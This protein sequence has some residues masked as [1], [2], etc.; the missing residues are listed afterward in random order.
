MSLVSLSGIGVDFGATTLLRDVTFTVDRGERWGIVGR[1]GTGKTTLF[2]IMTGEQQPTRGQIARMQG[3]RWSVLEQHRDYGDATTVWEAA[4][5]ACAE[6]LKLE[7]SLSEQANALAEAG[8]QVTDAQMD[9]Y[10]HDLERF[11]REGGYTL[12]PRV[13][14]VLHGLGFDPD[15][16]RTQA[17]ACLSGGERGRVGL[18]RQLIAGADVLLLDEPTNHLDLDTTQWLEGYLRE[19][20]R[21]VLVISHDRAFLATI[22]NHIAHVEDHTV[23]A[24]AGGYEAFV[25]QRAE[26]RLT[27]QRRFDQQ[28]KTIAKEEEYI[29]RNIAGVN[30][31]QA[32]GRRAR[33]ARVARL[34]PPP[35]EAG[36]MSLQFKARERGGDQVVVADTV[37]LE[38]GGRTLLRNFTGVVRRGDVVGLIGPNGVGKST[39]LRTLAGEHSPAD[40]S[41]R[42]GGSVTM[43]YYRQDLSQVPPSQTLYE[44]IQE[45]RPLWERG[46]IQ[47]HLGT[48]D[49]SGDAVLRRAG[50]LSGGEKARVALAIMMLEG[51]NLLVFD[52]PTNHLDVESI[53]SIEDAIEGYDGTVLLVSHDRALLRSLV[54]KVWMLHD[55]K[56]SEYA[57]D[58]AEW[59]VASR[60]RAHA[61]SVQASEDEALRRVKERQKTH[62]G[63]SARKEGQASERKLRRRI[64]ELEA[65]IATRE[66]GVAHL[67]AALDDPALYAPGE[68]GARAAA[69]GRELEEA[70]A[71]LD[72]ALEAWTRA[73]EALDA[74][75]N[76][77][78][79]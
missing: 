63:D 40:G 62:K 73:T 7:R 64:E 3:V 39:L 1:N 55:G 27:R 2:R 19:T 43:A 52:E 26:R 45:R 75:T 34:A 54:T 30:S 37:T 31:A 11:D 70:R 65:E 9:R 68:T 53:E 74:A 20:D 69:L 28:R 38:I 24:Y 48:F 44:I 13:D 21:T 12:A 49:F 46:A 18:A 16:A 47:N 25:L 59:E 15:A 72:E 6:L 79:R 22:A 33:L 5:G 36:T 56:I 10:S 60:E 78:R 67:S 29:R 17:L 77:A 42:L 71:I 23:E 76:G 50:T 66:A 57:G 41:I 51:A 4:A 58:F 35:G 32:K 61:A 14:A 8:D